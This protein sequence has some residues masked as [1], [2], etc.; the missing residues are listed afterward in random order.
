MLAS[1]T[2]GSVPELSKLHGAIKEAFDE[3]RSH[4]VDRLVR[5]GWNKIDATALTH[6]LIAGIEGAMILARI[7]RDDRVVIKVAES[8]SKLVEESQKR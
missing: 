8:L 2:V 7:D 1:T 5:D 6:T 4:I 3:W